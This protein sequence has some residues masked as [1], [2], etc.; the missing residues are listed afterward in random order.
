MESGVYTVSQ[1]Y[2]QMKTIAGDD[3]PVYHERYLKEALERYYGDS[4]FI[5]NQE[6]R[7][8]VV[9]FRKL[10]STHHPRLP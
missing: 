5:T 4:I 3:T 2:D 10:Y 9:C 8:D 1:L 7:K 6:R